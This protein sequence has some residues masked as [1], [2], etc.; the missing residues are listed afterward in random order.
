MMWC[1]RNPVRL[2]YE[3]AELEALRDREGWLLSFAP[4]LLKGLKFVVDFDIAVNGEPFQ[5]AL[6]YPAFFPDTPP[7]VT[8]RDGRRLSEHQYGAGGEMC[9]EY[10]S[11]NW[12][13]SITGAML[14]ESTY[15]LLAG[16][17]PAV[18]E[19]AVVPSAHQSTLGQRLRGASFRFFLT[20]E[21]HNYAATLTAGEYRICHIAD[22]FGPK[23][24]W[25]AYVSS[26]GSPETVDWQE[27]AIPSRVDQGETALLLR[28]ESLNELTISTQASLD[29][30][31]VAICGDEAFPSDGTVTTR[32]TV[33]ADHESASLY[34][35]FFKDGE[36][37]FYSYLTINLTD[38]TGGR[39]PGQYTVL[40]TKKV[41]LIG[42]GSLGSKIATSL[43]RSGV[44]N[45]VLVDDDIMKPG[46]LVRHDLDATSL[47]A[48]KADALAARLKAVSPYINVSARTVVLGGQESSGTTASVLDELATCDLLIDATADPQAFNFV[49]AAARSTPRPMLWAEVYAGGVGGFVARL[50]PNIEPPPHTARHQYIGWCQQQGVTWIGE[51]LNYESRTK[52]RP[53]IADDADV[54][55]IAAHAAR[56]TTDC[57]VNPASSAFPHPAYV[58]GLAKAWVFTEPLDIRPVDFVAEGQWQNTDPALTT[59]AVGYLLTLLDQTK[60]AN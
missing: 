48:H 21:F 14:V 16:E 50:R 19:R 30:L 4:S 7:T 24:T 31:I 10:R 56:M 41:G 49:A 38:D 59:E 28:V 60:D 54:A 32:R 20:S 1:I 35:S 5:F 53:V 47:G 34:L 40:S 29:A 36:W 46:N 45:F 44:G 9:L 27:Y 57:L 52:E 26:V 8:P 15:R 6:E 58:I 51:D 18:N 37:S 33:V 2:K 12:D 22:I 43:A 11:D 23:Q 3:V 17:R 42:C 55:V 25:T 39:L 13:P